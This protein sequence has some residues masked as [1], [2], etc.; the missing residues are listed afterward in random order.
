MTMDTLRTPDGAQPGARPVQRVAQV[1]LLDAD[2]RVQ[3]A[4]DV[5][6]WPVDLGR[7]LDNQIVLHDP[8]VAAHHARLDLDTDGRLVLLARPS[9]NGVRIDEGAGVVGL[10]EGAQAVLAPLATWHLGGS[11]LRVRQSDDVLPDELPLSV[12]AAAPTRRVTLALLAAMLAWAGGT[13]WL[14]SNADGTWEDYLPGLLA[15]LGALGLWSASWGVATKIFTRHFVLMPHLRIVL[16]CGLAIVAAETA[17]AVVAFVFDWPW[18]SR[19]RSLV[20]W[21]LAATMLAQHLRIVLPTHGRR[22][23]IAVGTVAALGLSWTMA[24]QWQRTD[25]LF[26]ELYSA[27]LLPPAWRLARAQPT[28]V[29]VD[30]LRALEEPLLEKARKAAAKDAEP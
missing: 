4:W 7:A 16:S 12:V 25:R 3:Q 15:L 21:A 13:L 9:R 23:G 1:E 19:A 11:R 10:S 29:L 5:A 6:A 17:L 28:Q 2:G 24:M 18:A 8:H 26:G 22:I 30:D 27:T 14:E 20:A